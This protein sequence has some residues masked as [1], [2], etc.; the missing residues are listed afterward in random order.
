[1][2]FEQMRETP[3]K[4]L[5]LLKAI[6][7]E[8]TP[9]EEGDDPKLLQLIVDENALNS[10]ILDMVLIEKAASL[11][12]YLKMD[13]KLRAMASQMTTDAL[14]LVLPQIVEEY[15]RGLDIDFYLSM[16]H[17]LIAAKIP[18]SK[19]SGFQ[20]DKNG[21]FRFVLNGS[22]TVLVQKK[23]NEWEE[24]RSVFA[25]I[26]A[27]GKVVMKEVSETEKVM[28]VLP[29]A[30]EMSSLKIFNKDEEEQVMEQMV[31]TSG[32]NV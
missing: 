4:K 27:K 29:K 18:D 5:G 9:T 10:F 2:Y 22:A 26:I 11:R 31:L 24:A 3:K 25:S 13:P 16:S 6:D 32:L 12:E 14:G 23:R 8:F 1:M 7:S 28:V 19:V 30:L 21:N 15:E 17:S 20:M